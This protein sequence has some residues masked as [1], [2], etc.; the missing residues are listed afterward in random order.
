[1]STHSTSTMQSASA[2]TGPACDR[3]V[4][5]LSLCKTHYE[6]NRTRR[7]LRPIR[8]IIAR[9]SFP[10]CTFPGCERTHSAKGL[11]QAHYGQ[12]RKGRSLTPIRSWIRQDEWGPTCRYPGCDQVKHSR[13]LCSVH[14]GRGVSQFAR[15][16]ILE[17]QNGRCL[18]GC[19]DPGPEGWHLDHAHDHACSH[20]TENYCAGCARGLL[21]LSC[22]RHG[23]AWY[24][25]TWR[26]DPANV[27]ISELEAWVNRRLMFH[28]DLD[29]PGVSVSIVERN[30]DRE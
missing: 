20:A 9:G 10:A 2:C 4:H 8:G 21:C 15:D 1:M 18:C 19:T 6:Q 11:C 22:N 26:A 3:P 29:A 28:G 12:K 17:A 5:S 23:V 27:P 30:G 14:Y 16:A 25:G 13:G 7:P 24:E